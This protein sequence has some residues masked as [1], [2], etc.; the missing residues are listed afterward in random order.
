MPFHLKTKF[1][2]SCIASHKMSFEDGNSS[3]IGDEVSMCR[4]KGTT[5]TVI[6]FE[7]INKNTFWINFYTQLSDFL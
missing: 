2:W 4:H 1:R 3:G 5:L 6:I 7:N